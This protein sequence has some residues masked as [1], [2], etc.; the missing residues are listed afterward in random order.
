MS[1]G[2]IFCVTWDILVRTQWFWHIIPSRNINM[3][4]C[5]VSTEVEWV[6]A[7]GLWDTSLCSLHSLPILQVLSESGFV[8]QRNASTEELIWPEDL[9]WVWMVVWEYM[10]LISDLLATWFTHNCVFRPYIQ[11]QE[12]QVS[13]FFLGPGAESPS[14]IY[15]HFAWNWALLIFK[16]LF[17]FLDLHY[18]QHPV[19]C[20]SSVS[21]CWDHALDMNDWRLLLSLFVFDVTA[22]CV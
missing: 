16:S 2:I 7:W 19:P 14:V 9:I 21:L 4:S 18:L 8:V 11:Q 6:T 17:R 15:C 3:Q 5:E 13:K 20:H 10:S 1:I 12:V 22:G